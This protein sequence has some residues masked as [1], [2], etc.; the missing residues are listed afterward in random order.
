M[1]EPAGYGAAVLFGPNTWNFK[2]VVEL[3]LGQEAALVVHTGDE[4]TARLDELLSDRAK[5]AELG[6]RARR[7]VQAQRGAT[8]STVVLL[9]SVLPKAG[10]HEGISNDKAA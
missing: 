1:I 8:A 10:T 2:D 7:L 5:T 4:L 6:D 3:L 9:E